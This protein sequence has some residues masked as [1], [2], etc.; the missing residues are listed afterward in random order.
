MTELLRRI[1]VG[2][3]TRNRPI[4]LQVLLASYA[5]MAI[6]ANTQL[7]FVIVENNSF[8][9]LTEIIERFRTSVPNCS[10]QYE[11]ESRLGIAYVRNRVLDI[12]ISS[13]HDLLTFADDDETVEPDWLVE[14]L[15]E[16]DASNL[17]IVGGPVRPAQVEQ[18]SFF[19]KVVWKGLFEST[20]KYEQRAIQRREGGKADRILIATGSWMGNLAFFR[21]T[22]LRFDN[23]LALNGGEDWKLYREATRIG[24][25][26]GWTPHAVVFETVPRERLTLTYQF[27]RSRDHSASD[28]RARFAE[29][30]TTALLRLP[31]S[32][33]SRFL[34]LMTHLLKLP[35][36]PSR[37]LVLAASYLGHIAGS[38]LAFTGKASPHYQTTTGK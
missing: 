35:L 21:A 37:S 13:G 9:T 36:R 22:G 19:E 38:F 26:T 10:V 7:H 3:V 15:A 27:R 25:R 32:I 12:A 5:K 29:D 11:V 1:C 16:R 33:L 23:H 28:L 31:G 2:T 6:P 18:M 8:P 20:Q 14:L 17:D 30:R 4:M 24:A 34:K